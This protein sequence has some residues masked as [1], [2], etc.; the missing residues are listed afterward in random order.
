MVVSF[1]QYRKVS[2]DDKCSRQFLQASR[3]R[4]QNTVTPLH[5]TRRVF[6]KRRYLNYNPS[7][8]FF[9]LL[10]FPSVYC[11]KFHSILYFCRLF[12]YCHSILW[13][14]IIFRTNN[15][16]VR[17]LDLKIAFNLL[18]FIDNNCYWFFAS[19]LLYIIPHTVN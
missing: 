16:N 18:S 15:N 1:T 11:F 9:S 6:L 7:P 2:G 19:I 17:C 4:R 5:I 3:R 13:S 12:L 14:T 10:L 8:F